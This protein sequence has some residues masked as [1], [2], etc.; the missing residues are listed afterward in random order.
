M[1]GTTERIRLTAQDTR[2]NPNT[3]PQPKH[4]ICAG[5]PLKYGCV[6]HPARILRV[7]LSISNLT[8]GMS[9]A[10]TIKP[11]LNHIAEGNCSASA[12]IPV[13]ATKRFCLKT[14]NVVL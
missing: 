9:K 8:V 14:N 7:A 6:P 13:N 3:A 4:T 11:V 2:I 12:V 10:D 5:D 1:V